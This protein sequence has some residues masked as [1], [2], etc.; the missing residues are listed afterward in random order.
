M[1]P[2]QGVGGAPEPK[3]D[4]TEK[5]RSEREQDV[6]RATAAESGGKPADDVAVISSEARAAAEI[7]KLIRLSKTQEDVRADRV[8]EAKASIERGD[9]KRPEEVATVAERLMKYLS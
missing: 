3:S 2:I 8:A 1:V 9:Y 5:V 4:R 6:R 7:A